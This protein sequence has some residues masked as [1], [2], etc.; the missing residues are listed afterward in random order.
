M[1]NEE[2]T[3][4]VQEASSNLKEVQ[5]TQEA[6]TVP[7]ERFA[8]KVNELNTLK[9]Q[10]SNSVNWENKHN[11]LTATLESERAAWK[12][13]QSLYQAGI[14][15]EEVIEL[16]K[17]RFGKSGSDDFS[18]WLSSDALQD[19]LLKTH[20]GQE[21]KTQTEAKIAQPAPVPT[22]NPNN[23]VQAPP[24]PRGDFSPESVQQMSVDDLKKNYARIAS[25]WGYRSHNL[26]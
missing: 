19:P 9:E 8:S 1:E 18:S 14:T 2:S 5:Q 26:K 4:E 21:T 11:E 24:P 20:L 17:W 10:L 16:A 15:S 6:Q 13:T 22:A 23:G 7:Y 25:A 12:Q 3:V